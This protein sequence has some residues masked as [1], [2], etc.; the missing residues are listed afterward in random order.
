[1]TEGTWWSVER[2][3]RKLLVSHGVTMEGRPLPPRAALTVSLDA[4]CA[5]AIA[6]VQHSL[7]ID[8]RFTQERMMSLWIE[9]QMGDYPPRTESG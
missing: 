8:A 5:L 7:E 4:A 1:M 3:G 9:E 6:L 2:V